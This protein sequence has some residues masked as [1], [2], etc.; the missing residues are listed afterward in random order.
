M[1]L[2]TT[3]KEPVKAKCDIY[4][5]KVFIK[6]KDSRLFTFPRKYR[7]KTEL[8]DNIFKEGTVLKPHQKYCVPEK[9][10]SGDNKGHFYIKS[11]AIHTCSISSILEENMK[12]PKI[13]RDDLVMYKCII[14]KDSWYFIDVT[15][16]SYASEQIKILNEVE[17]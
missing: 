7:V 12:S 15:G 1:S 10:Y 5:Y 13:K 4:C 16:E 17:I 2:L 8:N 3:S 14:P 11:G 9:I 6:T